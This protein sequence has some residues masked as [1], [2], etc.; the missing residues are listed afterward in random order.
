MSAAPT[1]PLSLLRLP[2]AA[3]AF[4]TASAGRT[5]TA[6]TVLGLLWLV[7]A[8]TGSYGPAASATAA[9]AVAEAMLAP[10][11]A[12]LV[13]RHGQVRVLPV[14]ALAHAGAAS[15]AVALAAAGA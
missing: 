14:Q 3:A 9:F 11:A 8:A 10:C 6:M 13:D 7:H 1:G 5:G 15:A 2:G 12:R 4:L